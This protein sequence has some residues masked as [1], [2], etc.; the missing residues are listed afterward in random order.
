MLAP[1][2]RL[3][4]EAQRRPFTVHVEE[5]RRPDASICNRRHEQ[6]DFVDE[7]GAKEPAVD[8]AAALEHECSHVE[9][10]ADPV[11]RENEID[12]SGSGEQVGNATRARD[13]GYSSDT[14][15]VRIATTWSPSMSL[16][17]QAMGSM[18]MRPQIQ[19][20]AS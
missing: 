7:P 19:P 8:P 1:L 18:V 13:A 9:V 15:S 10:S 12:V 14:R 20:S 5:G 3:E 17:S 11:E 6:A 16:D 2:H 4:L